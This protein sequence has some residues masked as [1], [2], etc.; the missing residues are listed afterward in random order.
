[1]VIK[2][3]LVQAQLLKFIPGKEKKIVTERLPYKH[4]K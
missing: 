4:Q 3:S 1:M 2:K